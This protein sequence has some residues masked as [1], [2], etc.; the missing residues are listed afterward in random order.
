MKPKI[1][2]DFKE[3]LFDEDALKML[4]FIADVRFQPIPEERFLEEHRDAVAII[5][6]GL[7]VDK[8][9]LDMAPKLKIVAVFG[10][11]YDHVDV[12]ECTRRGIYVTNTPGALS[13]AVADLVIGFMLCLARHI[14][15]VD[16]YVRKEWAKGERTLPLGVSLSGKKIG[17]IG[18]GRIGF[19]VA[20]RAKSFEM[21][22]L[23]TDIIR[24]E[25]AELQFGA[26]RMELE[27][28]LREADFVTIHV[29]L[30]NKTRGL[31]GRKELSLMKKTAFLINT[32]R[33]AVIDQKALTEFL[34]EKR[35]AGAGLDVFEPE[36]IPLDDPLLQ[37]DNVVLSA[38]RA[39]ATF[40]ARK[41][42][43]ITDAEEILRVLRGERPLNIVPEQIG[44]VP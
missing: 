36:P 40:E 39:W 3:E 13:D 43:A 1:L 7:K 8:M 35:I 23:Y 30:T 22:I 32:S 29:P 26:K 42:M 24:R 33:G 11:G 27:E 14:L 15:K 6:D 25:D 10:V 21:D 38:H 12:E 17:I 16:E 34:K 31:I 2:V 28:L 41:R 37:L 5:A 20:K 19:E 18:M 44:R 9:R 4:T